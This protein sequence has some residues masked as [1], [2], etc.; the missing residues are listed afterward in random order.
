[1]RR[2]G[3]GKALKANFSAALVVTAI[4]IALMSCSNPII[5]SQKPVVAT[6]AA[7]TSPFVGTTIDNGDGTYTLEFSIPDRSV[8]QSVSASERSLVNYENAGDF[9]GVINYYQLIAVDHTDE[10]HVWA[11]SSVN[12]AEGAGQ[13]L[14]VIV[15]P[16][17]TYHLLLL[18]GHK[19]T[20]DTPALL[21][22]GYIKYR[23]LSGTNSIIVRMVP[24][25]I[26]ATITKTSASTEW[27]GIRNI[28]WVKDEAFDV[29]IK[30]FSRSAGQ[31]NDPNPHGNA[32][33]PL[34]LAEAR[35][36]EAVWNK[37]KE[38][39]PFNAFDSSAPN[40]VSKDSPQY[41]S[42]QSSDWDGLYWTYTG[43]GETI[44]SML[45]SLTLK[46]PTSA[47]TGTVAAYY[48]EGTTPAITHDAKVDANG[49]SGTKTTGT[50]KYAGFESLINTSKTT[51]YGKFSF[52]VT[53]VPFGLPD[54]AW[55]NA[56]GERDAS[57]WTIGGDVYLA[58]RLYA[59]KGGLAADST[60]PSSM[61]GTVD[62]DTNVPAGISWA[63][64]SK[65]LQY[66]ADLASQAYALDPTVNPSDPAENQRLKEIWVEAGTYKNAAN[67][68]TVVDIS[69]GKN[70]VAL[71]GGFKPATDGA[72]KRLAALNT[73]PID[74][75]S[76]FKT[77]PALAYGNEYGT[78]TDD[79]RKTTL[80]ANNG[81]TS[82]AVS[83]GGAANLVLDGFTITGGTHSG[84]QIN[85]A[86]TTTLFTNLEIT[87]NTITGTGGG[88]IYVLDGAPKL[89]NL[90]VTGNTSTGELGG[91]IHI[92]GNS[93]ALIT[94]ALFSG[95]DVID[96][97]GGGIAISGANPRLK[98]II[99]TGNK[100]K[101]N[102]GGIYNHGSPVIVNA[103]ISGNTC[104]DKPTGGAQATGGA[105]YT[106][107]G[108]MV[109]VNALI[110]GNKTE[111]INGNDGNAYYYGG[112]GIK[113]ND[114]QLNLINCTV[115]GNY[116]SYN[117]TDVTKTLLPGGGIMVVNTNGSGVVK[118]YN[119]LVLGNTGTSGTGNDV[120]TSGGQFIAYNSL[121]GGYT[122]EQLHDGV[123][124]NG[125]GVGA[126]NAN[127]MNY[128][129]SIAEATRLNNLQHFFIE[130]N[131]LPTM[132]NTG[133]DKVADWTS[134]LWDFHLDGDA[135]TVGAINIGDAAYYGTPYVSDPD[136]LKNAADN[137]SDVEGNDRIQQGAPDMGAYESDMLDLSAGGTY[138][139]GGGTSPSTT[140]TVTNAKPQSASSANHGY[141]TINGV[142]TAQITGIVAGAEVI[143]VAMPNTNYTAGTITYT[144]GGGAPV[145]ISGGKFTMPAGDVT[146]DVQF[147]EVPSTTYTVTNARPQSANSA[148]HGH[149]TV[150]GNG[151]AQITGIE[152][153]AEVIVVVI[154]ASGYDLLSLMCTTA[155]GAPDTMIS[156]R[157]FTMPAENVTVNATFYRVGWGGE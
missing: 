126:D 41:S 74:R 2:R 111:I 115:S 96:D 124:S 14:H 67:S 127:G 117:K 97:K 56:Y 78:V 22:S 99:V 95:N 143:V 1:M 69:G 141:L 39:M 77:Y 157:K 89:D 52:G 152:A 36:T 137:V 68:G 76:W 7:E 28:A 114:G 103:L 55:T 120:A 153:G 63:T 16:G 140:Y 46:T 122:A 57:E 30:L 23:V 53:Y 47:E 54:D 70:G 85:N 79:T 60:V 19:G 34:L 32:L 105:L 101:N 125:I 146:V 6:S 51:D 9:E 90:T 144:V 38:S 155:A 113:V 66:L 98:N 145:T 20:S 102:G 8:A 107:V 92:A 150:N 27:A 61:V 134:P 65:N 13:R 31:N 147:T 151:N 10:N 86:P 110:S 133:A 21:G 139:G 108:N 59:K 35:G 94:N 106:T 25:L 130:F 44:P 42:T 12:G 50:L 40:S 128:G 131:A 80:D 33:W 148:N 87:G 91:G 129:T 132:S 136:L 29:A 83:V 156:D 88:G 93:T 149:L 109:L 81:A 72:A 119:S 118:A 3:F 4:T 37:F 62:S 154:P 84:L 49:S 123:S 75:S 135:A 116:A 45:D 17:E 121:V 24:V 73:R 18:H 48:S 138:G 26:D 64:A 71:Y 5:V 100:S 15:K 142:V 11:M 58:Y 82:A 112:G 43:T 104:T